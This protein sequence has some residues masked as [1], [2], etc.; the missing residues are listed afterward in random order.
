[1]VDRP[2]ESAGAINWPMAIGA[3]VVIHAA[4]LG[5]L[6]FCSN[7]WPNLP[8]GAT[9]EEPEVASV[10][11]PEPPK[12]AEPPKPEFEMY[13]V[14]PGDFM[15]RIASRN[16]CTPADLRRLNGDEV[17]NSTLYP[18]QVLKIPAKN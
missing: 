4:L 6:W 1:M 16:G 14:K 17:F 13:T 2:E 3:S 5:T 12:P 9:E 15:N 7:G 18:G 11:E 10:P 8:S